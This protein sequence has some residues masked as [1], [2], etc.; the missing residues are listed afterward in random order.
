MRTRP[1]RSGISA[2][3]TTTTRIWATRRTLRRTRL[4]T[5]FFRFKGYI[6]RR[7]AFLLTGFRSSSSW[8]SRP[9]PGLWRRLRRP[10]RLC[11]GICQMIPLRLQP[12][13]RRSFPPRPSAATPYP[14]L[15]PR[16]LLQSVPPQPQPQSTSPV[17]P[18]H[19][20]PC[21]PAL[22]RIPP[23]PTSTLQPPLQMASSDSWPPCSNS[24]SNS[25]SSRITWCRGS[26]VR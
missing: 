10:P 14:V 16:P 1:R 5:I 20:H 13:P 4:I 7:T 12:R 19:L 2:T 21:L 6:M 11:L 8:T 24:N 3:K 17:T 26:S 22:L 9:Q 18:T 15:T 23:G 25:S